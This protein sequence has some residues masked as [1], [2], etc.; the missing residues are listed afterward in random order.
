M[1][2]KCGSQSIFGK[3][4]DIGSNLLSER[5]DTRPTKE[6]PLVRFEPIVR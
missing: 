6:K 5:L 2:T 3:Q 4:T 1:C